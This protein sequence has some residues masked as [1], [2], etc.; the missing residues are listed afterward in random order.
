MGNWVVM[1]VVVGAGVTVVAGLLMR[2][3]TLQ[4]AIHGMAAA[5]EEV[6]RMHEAALQDAERLHADAALEAAR[7]QAEAEQMLM[8]AEDELSHART[9]VHGELER[10]RAIAAESARASRRLAR[11]TSE[12]RRLEEAS[13]RSQPVYEF[14][15]ADQF[16]RERDRVRAEQKEMLRSGRVIV[17]YAADGGLLLGEGTPPYPLDEAMRARVCKLMV[18]AFNGEA[19]AA[20]ARVATAG[21]AARLD[22]KIRRVFDAINEIGADLH[23][24]IAPAYRQLKLAELHL[25]HDSAMHRDADLRAASATERTRDALPH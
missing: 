21:N 5:E 22:H 9:V 3:T 2:I 15:T 10:R 1:V 13:Q 11:I 24:A 17:R 7:L 19:D 25:A 14:E 18:R 16:E 8:A 23:V 12:L 6:A 4:R 20:I